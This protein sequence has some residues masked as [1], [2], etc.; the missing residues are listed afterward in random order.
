MYVGRT[1]RA[2]ALLHL[3]VDDSKS[4]EKRSGP[5]ASSS[6]S[7]WTGRRSMVT[8]LLLYLSTMAIGYP[9]SVSDVSDDLIH[10]FKVQ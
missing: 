10:T 8:T 7:K 9:A 2:Q 3:G 6:R 1:V 4:L 5:T